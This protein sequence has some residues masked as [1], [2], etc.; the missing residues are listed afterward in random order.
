MNKDPLSGALAKSLQDESAAVDKRFERADSILGARG[1]PGSARHAKPKPPKKIPVIRDTF[2]FPEFDYALLS[3]LQAALLKNGHN[4]SKSELVRAGLK[5]LA[6]MRPA[7][8]IKT[9]KA[10]EK[11]KP[12]RSRGSS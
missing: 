4:V 8:L 2:S 7:Q 1:G 9:A 12:G 11:L 5:T 10:V 6:Q 3:E